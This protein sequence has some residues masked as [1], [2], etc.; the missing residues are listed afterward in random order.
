MVGKHR[1]KNGPPTFWACAAE[2]VTPS[3]RDKIEYIVYV[4]Q[5]LFLHVC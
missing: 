2:G 4:Y 1:G 5:V 3:F